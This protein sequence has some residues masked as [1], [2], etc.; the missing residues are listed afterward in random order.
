MAMT[1]SEWLTGKRGKRGEPGF[2]SQEELARRMGVGRSRI[3]Q[4]EEAGREPPSYAV[5]AKVHAA[6]GTSDDELIALGIV[7][8]G[9]RVPMQTIILPPREP[10][11]S[12]DDDF[13]ASLSPRQKQMLRR[14][15]DRADRPRPGDEDAA[16][17]A[18]PRRQA[19][20]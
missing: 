12:E 13:F 10:A 9:V 19:K 8:P 18:E 6:L 16:D 2:V 17:D 3:V 7:R 5:R 15:L 1:W 14:L 4:L 11:Q 20:P